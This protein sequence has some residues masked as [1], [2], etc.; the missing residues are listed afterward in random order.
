[1]LCAATLGTF[2]HWPFA[3]DRFFCVLLALSLLSSSCATSP[4]FLFASSIL[5]LSSL[6]SSL[7]SSSHRSTLASSHPCCKLSRLLAYL[8]L[9]CL[10][11]LFCITSSSVEFCLISNIFVF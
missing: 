4:L 1:M 6:F 7:T 11:S 5:A 10:W 3:F 9:F 2:H 8:S